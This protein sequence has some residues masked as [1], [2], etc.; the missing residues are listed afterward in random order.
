MLLYESIFEAESYHAL[1]VHNGDVDT[2]VGDG[3]SEPF[4][5]VSLYINSLMLLLQFFA[6]AMA[7]AVVAHYRIM[8]GFRQGLG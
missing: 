7:T 5:V 8:I 1:C 2:E 6:A 4:N 3:L